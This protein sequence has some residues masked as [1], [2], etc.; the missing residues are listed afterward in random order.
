LKIS[1]GQPEKKIHIEKDRKHKNLTISCELRCS[2]RTSS[3][4]STRGCLLLQ[5]RW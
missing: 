1:N 2:R 3:S 4:W 5:A